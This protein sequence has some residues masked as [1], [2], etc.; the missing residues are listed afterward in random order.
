M[1]VLNMVFWV[2][3]PLFLASLLLSEFATGL[4][5][6]R[7]YRVVNAALV[8]TVVVCSGAI[9][10]YEFARNPIAETERGEWTNRQLFY[11]LV[12]VIINTGGDPYGKLRSASR[13]GRAGERRA[14][15]ARAR[16]DG[17]DHRAML[18][19]PRLPGPGRSAGRRALGT[20][21]VP[22]TRHRSPD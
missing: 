9:T 13:H 12:F 14:P 22:P 10:S 8:I 1:R 17:R 3:F 7:G 19:Q 18:G 5:G 16:R 11:M 20:V 15:Q 21:L 4:F 6:D 2:A